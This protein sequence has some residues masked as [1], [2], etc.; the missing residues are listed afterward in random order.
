[1]GVGGGWGRGWGIRGYS[2]GYL[3]G[4]ETW[5]SQSTYQVEP[6]ISA[7]PLEVHTACLAG[8]PL[9]GDSGGDLPPLVPPA[10]LQCDLDRDAEGLHEACGWPEWVL[11]ARAVPF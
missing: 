2:L 9:V 4:I 10:T 11:L 5:P 7:C 3:G 1:M 6:P 8:W